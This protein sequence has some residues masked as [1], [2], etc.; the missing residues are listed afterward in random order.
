[1]LTRFFERRELRELNEHN[2]SGLLGRGLLNTD[3]ASGI[4]ISPLRALQSSA[5]FAC[6]RVL[7]EGLAMLPLH[8]YQRVAR[9]REMATGH[10]L[11]PLLHDLPN[12]EMTSYSLRELNMTHLC[13]RGN[14]IN[15]LD[16]NAA[17]EW[18]G[19]WP[20]NPDT[21]SALREQGSN[22]LFYGIELPERFGREYRIVPAERIWHIHGPSTDGYWGLTPIALA[23]QAIGMALATEEYG[24]RFF[25]NGAQPGFVLKHPGK[26]K[27][28][29]YKRLK[30]AWEKRHMGLDNAHKVAILE[31][32]MDV[33]K[34]GVSPEEAQ[35]LETRKFQATEIARF[36]RVPPHMIADLDRATFTNIEQ[37]SL[38]FVVY[39]LMPW[40]T[41]FEQEIHRSLLTP[42]ERKVYFV[43]FQLDALLRGDIQTRY[44]AY[45][46]ATQNGWMS[47]NDVLELEDRNLI[48]EGDE[49]LVQLSMVPIDQ[50][51]SGAL[52]ASSETAQPRS[53][54]QIASQ[55]EARLRLA[56]GKT[57]AVPAPLMRAALTGPYTTAM[58]AFTLPGADAASLAE[59]LSS[60]PAEVA[61]QPADQMHL[62]LAYLGETGAT[63]MDQ[64]RL[65]A[66][67]QDFARQQAPLRG[68]IN[69]FG[70]FLGTE[71]GTDVLYASFDALDLA[72]F[73]TALAEALEASGC[74]LASVH[75]FVPHI[76]LAY[77]PAGAPTPAI[78]LPALD[79]TFDRVDVYWDEQVT[80]IP[81]GV[82]VVAALSET[83]RGLPAD[84][85][86]RSRKSA[87]ARH[88]LQRSYRRVIRTVA[89]RVVRRESQ[90]ILT[91]ARKAFTSR[92]YGDFSTWLASFYQEHQQFISRQML[93]VMT[94]YAELV[95]DQAGEEIGWQADP[96]QLDRF[97]RAY[98]NSYADRHAAIN[99]EKL[100][101]LLERAQATGQDPLEALK[102]ELEAW[103]SDEPETIADRE[104]V[105]AN[106]AVAT[107]V[108]AMSGLVRVLKWV[109]LGESCPYCQ[110]L[111]GRTVGIDQVFLSKDEDYQPDGAERP[112]RNGHDV[113]HAPAH[114]GCDCQVVAGG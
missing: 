33:A 57:H 54:A 22:R 102:A 114:D 87:Q 49:H 84:L 26:L 4:H 78:D 62:T 20:I 108:Y 44:A 100:R 25:G 53:L 9:G 88:R 103:E 97:V 75:G 105:R 79:L 12:P 11:Y 76:T 74:P 58:V 21:V 106:N 27:D 71:D 6:T 101:K 90:D 40:L 111:N 104:S 112:L 73:R 18:S 98:T 14:A 95:A 59:S 5:V 56:R 89:E 109:S 7:S 1:M 19:I 70:R 110:S 3:T 48:E 113:K 50:L 65:L 32:G 17:G 68:T 13:L 52:D 82:P 38:E 36:F 69:G 34:L 15:Y 47:I 35:F 8:E 2:A 51:T 72:A 83:R 41:R 85:E 42:A 29:A 37:M 61:P 93:P 107:T 63:G 24:A 60:L 28:D 80:A 67:V 96:A 66:A 64:A 45:A 99:Q 91:Q 43:K 92:G 23:A 16:A 77:L 55:V 86:Q 39:T 81:L 30:E 94:A 46:Q 10:Y 31:E